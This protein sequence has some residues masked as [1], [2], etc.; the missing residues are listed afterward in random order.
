M[1]EAAL[2]DMG[3]AARVSLLPSLL[4]VESDIGRK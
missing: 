4:Y 3:F 1:P 2:K